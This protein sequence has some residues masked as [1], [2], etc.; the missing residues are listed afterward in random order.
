MKGFYVRV[1]CVIFNVLFVCLFVSGCDKN[2]LRRFGL[3]GEGEDE[4]R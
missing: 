2:S 4:V 3:N 1:L